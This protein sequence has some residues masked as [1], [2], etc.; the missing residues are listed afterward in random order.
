MQIIRPNKPIK[1]PDSARKV[2]N[3]S[4]L[5][6]WA[7]EPPTCPTFP[8]LDFKGSTNQAKAA[9]RIRALFEKEVTSMKQLVAQKIDQFVTQMDE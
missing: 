3:S 9:E 1:R 8:A 6:A 7:D 5:S 2:L 4:S